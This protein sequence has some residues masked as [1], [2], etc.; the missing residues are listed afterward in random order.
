MPFISEQVKA[1][2][3]KSTNTIYVF[4]CLPLLH[5]LKI[6]YLKNYFKFEFEKPLKID[7]PNIKIIPIWFLSRPRKILGYDI[8]QNQIENSILKEIERL[9]IDID[10]IHGHFGI[11]GPI[12]KR[13]AT[14][15][16]R[17]YVLTEHSSDLLPVID[18]LG[19]KELIDAYRSAK[20]VICVSESLERKVKY[21]N[22]AITNTVVIANGINVGKFKIRK[23]TDNRK[24]ICFIGH[25]IERK[26]I[27]ILMEACL[28]L[29]K[30]DY[31]FELNL[32]GIGNLQSYILEFTKKHGLQNS[33]FLK[34]V[35]SNEMINSVLLENDL[36]VL[37]SYKE[38]FGVV[39]I[40]ALASGLPVISTNCGGP[41]TIVT[42]KELGE[43]IEPGNPELLKDSIIKVFNN[44][45]SYDPIRL[46]NHI[47][48]H[49]D[50][51]SIGNK[52][53]ETYKK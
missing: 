33:I 27:K 39:I 41:E 31:E 43:I 10:I 35:V 40:E 37:P 15:C 36:F 13:I 14:K 3:F 47:K 8:V 5:Y 45:S 26:G 48:T 30:A 34:G 46:H 9:K 16:N 4:V 32:Y 25:L 19:K 44:Y 12:C 38:S 29:K 50:W 49:Y 22:N 52:I 28:L 51:D 11:L 2:S 18:Q 1:L 6:E 17:S 42:N 53:I 21:L 7:S 23:N 24:R 20:K